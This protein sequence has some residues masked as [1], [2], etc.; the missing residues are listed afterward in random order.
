MST[1]VISPYSYGPQN[2]PPVSAPNTIAPPVTA[3]NPQITP[4]RYY[5]PEIVVDISPAARNAFN[6]YIANGPAGTPQDGTENGAQ[7]YGGLPGTP[8]TVPRAAPIVKGNDDGT[9]GIAEAAETNE[10]QTCKNRKYQDSSSDPSV[11]FQAPTRISPNQAAGSVAAHESE[12]VAHEQAKA[13][14]EGRKIVSQTVT[15]QTSICPE[16]GRVYVSGGVTR[17]ITAKDN[18][19][20]QNAE[21]AKPNSQPG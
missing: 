5:N 17:T 12:H 1:G 21:K 3:L 14:R 20:E 19:P 7:R 8:Q 15:I 4:N 2:I 6:R 10:C 13:E 11:S 9:G 18:K 16:C